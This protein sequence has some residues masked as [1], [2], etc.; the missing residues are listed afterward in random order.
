MEFKT[1]DKVE[2]IDEAVKGT[3]VSKKG[4]HL[5]LLTQEGFEMEVHRSEV[6][7]IMASGALEI[8]RAEAEKAVREKETPS[9]KKKPGEKRGKQKASCMEIDL[10]IHELTDS[11]Q[12]MD[13]Y[14]MLSLQLETARKKLE[15]AMQHRIRTLVFIHGVGEG[16]LKAELEDLFGRYKNITYYDADFRKYG[17]GATEVYIHQNY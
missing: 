6:M 8:S 15:Y 10:H 11:T 13:N 2:L 5:T 3:I 4:N 17:F 7:K 9:R 1:G 16:V 12:G 14:D